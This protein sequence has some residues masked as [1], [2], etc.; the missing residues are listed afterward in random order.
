VVYVPAY[1]PEHTVHPQE[2]V[3]LALEWGARRGLREPLESASRTR[4]GGAEATAS[5]RLGGEF[6]QIWF[7]SNGISFIKASY[8]CAWGVRDVHRE[9]REALIASIR[10]T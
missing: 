3:D 5:Y 9:A 8:V 2:L 10:F 7:L 4:T 6:V 1:D